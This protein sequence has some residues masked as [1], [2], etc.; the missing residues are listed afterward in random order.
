[1]NRKRQINWYQA[2]DGDAIARHL[3]KMAARGWFLEKVGNFTWSFRRGEPR[4][5]RYAVT[6][7]P[8]ASI[9]DAGP[10]ERQETYIDYCKAAGWE[11]ITAYGPIQYFRNDRPNPVPIETDEAEKLRIIRRTMRKTLVLGYF[12]LLAA[13]MLYLWLKWRA[14]RYDPLSTVGS[15]MWVST[16]LLVVVSFIYFAAILIDYL[17]WCFRSKRSVDRGGSCAKVH[18]RARLWGGFAMLL[19]IAADLLL[20]LLPSI[21]ESKTGAIFIFATVGFFL[22]MAMSRLVF[23]QMKKRGF[24]R[25]A[26]RWAFIGISAVLSVIFSVS[27]VSFANWLVKSGATKRTPAYTYTASNGWK[28]DVY[29]DPLPVTL[30]DLGYRVTEDDHCNYTAEED[31]S[32]LVS[33]GKYAQNARAYESH[34]PALLYEVCNIRWDWLRQVCWDMILDESSGY[35]WE[36][37]YIH[38][39]EPL[40][41]GTLGALRD[42]SGQRYVFLCSD[43]IIRIHAEWELTGQQLES[44]LAALG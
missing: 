9:F 34:L 3:E 14:F 30:E 37:R 36:P 32:L 2:N 44:V 39:L 11:F 1:M 31:R 20:F 25:E 18:T 41:T 42:D 15:A 13:Q 17:V 5:V 27:T 40:P 12:A 26:T 21:L 16:V 22:I 38:A 24:S 33:Y 23:W 28:W 4:Q 6:Y 35:P 29:Q 7:F 43:R 10:T 8:D 19:F